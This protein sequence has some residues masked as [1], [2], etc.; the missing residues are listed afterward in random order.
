[1][2]RGVTSQTSKPDPVDVEIAEEVT[3][4]LQSSRCICG[5]KK[6]EYTSFCSWCL[7]ALHAELRS[8]LGLSFKGGFI[9]YYTRSKVHL[10]TIGRVKEVA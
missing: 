2:R 9:D 1:M 3:R 10:V 6:H 4:E 7:K 8:G 5:N